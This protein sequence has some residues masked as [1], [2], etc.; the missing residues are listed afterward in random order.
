MWAK[1]GSMFS[2]RSTKTLFT[3]PMLFPWTVPRDAFMSLRT[4]SSRK[5][6]RIVY[7][8][9]WESRVDAPNRSLLAT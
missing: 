4:K 3:L 1:G 5:D 6:A 7:A 8:E 2:I 9:T